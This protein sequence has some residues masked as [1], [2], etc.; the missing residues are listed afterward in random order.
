[1]LERLR[2]LRREALGMNRRN[3]E[4][5]VPYNPPGL[6]AVVDYKPGTKRRLAA[7]EIPVPATYAELGRQ[8]DLRYLASILAPHSSF[9]VKPARGA[10][11]GG[12]VVVAGRSGDAFVKASGAP[13]SLADLAAHCSDILAGAYAR[14]THSDEVLVEYR[15]Q[16]DPVLGA[17]SYRGV[18]DVRVFVFR[19][20]PV[21]AMIRLPTRASDGRANLHMGGMAV[22]VD[23][24]SGIT[25]QGVLRG[26]PTRHHP[27]LECDVGGRAIPEWDAMLAIAARCY[28]A[29]PLGYLGVDLVLDAEHGPMVL[30]LNARPGLTIQ[31][32]NGR[33][34]RTA[35]ETLATTDL[36]GLTVAE[37][38]ALGRG[39]AGG[40]G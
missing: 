4:F 5:L 27:D 37:R 29:I 22:G 13:M 8:W 11:G 2:R 40:E 10:G 12:V 38:L 9:V 34:L 19:G 21:Q 6:Y 33:G 15:V 25:T 3:L 39:L 14:S 26:R 17:I 16:A 28:D 1:M 7:A 23:L 24:A 30:E 31:L 20:V 35:M 18:A 32:A 36:H